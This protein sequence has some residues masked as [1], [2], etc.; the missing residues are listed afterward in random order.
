MFLSP[1]NRFQFPGGPPAIDLS[2]PAA[3]KMRMVN[4]ATNGL[5]KNLLT[6]ISY[7][8]VD[9]TVLLTRNNNTI[10][11]SLG[12]PNIVSSRANV[13][14]PAVIP[15]ES[16]PQATIAAIFKIPNGTHGGGSVVNENAENDDQ[17]RPFLNIAVNGGATT[18]TVSFQGGGSFYPPSGG[19][20]GVPNGHDVFCVGVTD[21]QKGLARSLM[22]DMTT[23]IIRFASAS[24][25]GT[26]ACGTSYSACTYYT[27]ASSADATPCAASMLSMVALTLPQMFAWANDPWGFWYKRGLR[28]TIF[29]GVPKGG[30]TPLG[31]FVD[32]AGV[33]G[34]TPILSAD[35]STTTSA[36][37][38]LAGALAVTATLAGEVSGA[39]STFTQYYLWQKPVIGASD[40]VWGGLLNGDLDSID[41]VVHALD[42]R[43]PHPSSDPP[44][45]D[46]IASP[47]NGTTF[48]TA[49]HV[50]PSDTSRAAVSAL[51]QA[52]NAN[53]NM[54]GA[55][56]SG[57]RAP[58]ARE[59]HVHPTDTT[60]AAASAIPVM[61]TSP[62]NI[63]G[64]AAP[65]GG[66]Q[67]A[68]WDH[69][70][71]TD[72]SRA[73]SSDLANYLPLAGGALTGP[74]SLTGALTPS[75]TAGIVGTTTNNNANAGSVGEYPTPIV[76]GTVT[77]SNSTGKN[78]AQITLPAGDWDVDGQIEISPAGQGSDFGGAV[79]LTSGVYPTGIALG[80]AEYA[81]G[82]GIFFWA[83]PVGPLRVSV[84]AP[85]IVYLVA[86]ATFTGGACTAQGIIRARRVR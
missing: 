80:R 47:G 60:R 46:G 65:G 58:Y 39:D 7:G 50:H 52:S 41:A 5:F 36:F 32:L 70:H 71:P 57:T 73:A 83:S 20:P 85:T 35:I 86:F 23:G 67:Y 78:V 18:G 33:L 84:S 1:L 22:L 19:Y 4:I 34:S 56:A 38:E 82:N 77:L 13:P 81:G 10:G 44:Q 76:S 45:M 14:I 31:S 75:Q 16:M 15:R 61:S 29:L 6:G 42:G 66:P 3:R 72:I 28:K 21:Q 37:T 54:D 30:N 24:S 48:A 55:A 49:N 51:P 62:P 40:D 27:G 11:H 17:V 59:D 53:P 26:H 25:F 9:P 68:A 8:C 63:D 43:V 74:L 79:T 2:H 64:V 69:V 12:S